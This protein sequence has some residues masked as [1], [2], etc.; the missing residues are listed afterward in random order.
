ME[1]VLQSLAQADGNSTETSQTARTK[2]F[3]GITLRELGTK[4]DA[5]VNELVK[6]G[7]PMT[8]AHR[9]LEGALSITFDELLRVHDVRG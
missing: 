3:Q 8:R 5:A 9:A 4:W 1:A 6:V 2:Q 7:V